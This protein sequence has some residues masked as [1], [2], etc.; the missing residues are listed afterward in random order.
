MSII[1]VLINRKE[2]LG[3]DMLI[4][5]EVKEAD[6]ACVVPGDRYD[7][8]LYDSVFNELPVVVLAADDQNMLKMALDLGIPEKAIY[9]HRDGR[10]MCYDESTEKSYPIV[11]GG[12]RLKDLQYL[13]E[14]AREER[15]VAE[16]VIQLISD[17][18][19]DKE[20]KVDEK[21]ENKELEETKE[22]TVEQPFKLGTDVSTTDI[23]SELFGEEST[24]YAVIPNTGVETAKIAAAIAKATSGVRV[25]ASIETTGPVDNEPYIHFDGNFLIGDHNEL[26]TAKTIILEVRMPELIDLLLGSKH[27]RFIFVSGSDFRSHQ[28]AA[29]FISEWTSVGGHL[30]AVFLIGDRDDNIAG[31]IKHRFSN[32]PIVKGIDG[33]EDLF[34][35]MNELTIYATV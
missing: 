13:V 7:H 31:T 35:A 28:T 2:N 26:A 5:Q 15:W 24:V 25:E 20:K 17:V 1:K 33:D 23:V 9:V 27:A 10:I 11:R 22:N 16:P 32:I 14:R 19:D 30:D 8:V 6:V 21:R 4:V 34:E 29:N 3:K 12:I 18:K